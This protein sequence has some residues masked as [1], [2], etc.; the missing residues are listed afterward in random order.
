VLSDPARRAGYDSQRLLNSP[1][2]H[3]APRAGAP[4]PAPTPAL[5]V[6]P[7]TL[8]FGRVRKGAVPTADVEVGVT[9]GRTL[10]G[11]VRPS[12]PWIHLSVNSLF[13]DR[14]LVHVTVDTTMMDEGMHYT[15]AIVIDSVVY[16]V[17]SIPVSLSLVAAAKP[18]LRVTP[19]YLDFG[20]IRPGQSPKVIELTISNAGTG[21]LSGTLRPLQPWL[22]VSHSVFASKPAPVQVMACAD[23]LSE[24]RTYT[25]EVAIES[26]GG[27][28][29][30]VARL[31]V[32]QDHP[33]ASAGSRPPSR[34]RLFL[35]ERLNILTGQHHL[36]AEQ[37]QER[38]IIEYLLKRTR[39]GDVT[40][41]LQ[42]GVA[43]AQGAEGIAWRDDEGILRG[44]SQ[45]IAILGG[46]LE[47][48]HRWEEAG[49]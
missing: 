29:L 32:A 15:G 46:L 27:K 6:T 39:G 30:L 21:Y 26:T 14:T 47:R 2:A 41:M 10:I 25:G 44:T 36:T 4:R 28:G 38:N 49:P 8:A 24:G 9:E 45:A 19:T 33:G 42:K 23:G 17:R 22:S 5:L 37:K 13:S 34:D 16:G 35:E 31:D 43:A 48:L 40:D 3:R 7:H 1:R 12:V 20:E 11:D 18:V